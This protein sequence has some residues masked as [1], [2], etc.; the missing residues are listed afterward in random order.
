VAKR[1]RFNNWDKCA[2]RG[3]NVVDNDK[4][5]VAEMLQAEEEEKPNKYFNIETEY[6]GI[7]Y[8]SA[9]EVKEAQRLD[10]RKMAG[11]IV[12]WERQVVITI[13]MHGTKLCTYRMDFVA[14]YPDGSKDYIECKGYKTPVWRLKR[15]L[16]QLQLRLAEPESRYIIK[17]KQP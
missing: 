4:A 1:K 9:L 16:F 8:D 15:K 7:V 5:E 12:K 3:L 13:I 17:E 2:L 11:E 10:W 14:Y 6:N